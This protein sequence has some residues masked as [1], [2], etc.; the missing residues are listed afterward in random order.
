MEGLCRSV[1]KA[2]SA[3]WW[4]AMQPTHNLNNSCIDLLSGVPSREATHGD[5]HTHA[6]TPVNTEQG[7]PPSSLVRGSSLFFFSFGR[8]M[9]CQSVPHLPQQP[10]STAPTSPFVSL[11]TYLSV[12]VF[13]YSFIQLVVYLI[14]FLFLKTVE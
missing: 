6:L 7:W 11:L 8:T 12:C 5:V 13:I 9:T 1:P 4:D 3:C 10:K 14:R 2:K